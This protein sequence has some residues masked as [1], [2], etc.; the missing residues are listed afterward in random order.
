MAPV[1]GPFVSAMHV[2]M[3]MVMMMVMMHSTGLCGCNW[4][5]KGNGGKRC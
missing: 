5:S 2:V 3:M 4:Q 1:K